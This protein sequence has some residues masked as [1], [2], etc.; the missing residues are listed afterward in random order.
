MDL[1]NLTQSLAW[2]ERFSWLD[3]CDLP[4]EWAQARAEGRELGALADHFGDLLRRADDLREAP[5][6]ERWEF[7]QQVLALTDAVQRCPLQP[8]AVAAE[9]SDWVGLEALLTAPADP[10]D[11]LAEDFEDRLAGALTGRIAGC[12]LGKP[13]ETWSRAHLQEWAALSGNADLTHYWELPPAAQLE[14]LSAGHPL[15][16]PARRKAVE[17]MTL[18]GIQ[19]MPE[20]DDINYTVI[21]WRVVETSGPEFTT[22]DVGEF[23]LREVPLLH[24]CTA[25]RVAYRNLAAGLVP[26]A[27]A[28]HRNPYR[29]LIGAQIRGDFFGWCQLGRPRQAAAWAHRDAALSHTANGLYGEMWVAALLAL[30]PAAPDWPEA[31]RRSLA[32]LPPACRLAAELRAMLADHDTGQSWA[33]AV[34]AIH[35]RWDEASFYGWCHTISNAA[36]VAAALLHGG[37]DFTRTIGLAVR[38]GFDTDCNGATCG[39]L[40]GLRNGLASIPAHWV[41]PLRDCVETGV[42]SHREVSIRALAAEMATTVRR[43]RSA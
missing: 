43:V 1:P 28:T 8:S 25:E 22:E 5:A 21:G 33:V 3:G 36:V 12:L 24:T 31:L 34:D 39:S 13:V 23:W 9:P 4:V 30:A 41:E 38:S 26:P 10:A 16:D 27:S 42:A 19:R 14:S 40:L 20:D 2:A 15:R 7:R 18:P 35:R 6:A 29:E 17:K 11:G 32:Y 37:N